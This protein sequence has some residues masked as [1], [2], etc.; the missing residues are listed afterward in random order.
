L[1][2]ILNSRNLLHQGFKKPL[3]NENIDNI[4]QF[5]ASAKDYIMNLKDSVDG[6]PIV[7]TN[8]KTGFIGFLVCINSL[9]NLFS[10]LLSPP[11]NMTFLCTYKLSRP[12]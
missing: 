1:F 4:K 7:T 12:H 11:F 5:L 2:D 8:R 10:M 9:L 3:S 6:K